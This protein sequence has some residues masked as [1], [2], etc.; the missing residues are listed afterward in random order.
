MISFPNKRKVF[1]AN[2]KPRFYKVMLWLPHKSVQTIALAVVRIKW[3]MLKTA[4]PPCG[5]GAMLQLPSQYYFVENRYE[6]IH[7]R[8]WL[9]S[10]FH[11]LKNFNLNYKNNCSS[12]SPT[13]DQTLTSWLMSSDIASVFPNFYPHDAMWLVRSTSSS[14]QK[15]KKSTIWIVM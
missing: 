3:L 10:L 2:I 4:L 8:H 15:K 14:S 6:I 7:L 1:S 9:D 13:C 5:K 11:Y 12:G